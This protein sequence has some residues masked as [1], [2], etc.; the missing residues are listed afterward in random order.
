MACVNVNSP[1]YKDLVKSLDRKERF[2][3]KGV[4]SSYLTKNNTDKLPDFIELKGLM[5]DLYSTPNAGIDYRDMYSEVKSMIKRL[6]P[7]MSEKDLENRVKFVDKLELM[8]LRN[9]L[10]V[11]STFIN[12]TIFISQNIFNE[13][14]QNAITD[15]RHEVFHTIFNNFLSEQEQANIFE[16]FKRDNPKYKNEVDKEVLE[17]AMADLF[18]NYRVDNKRSIPTIIKD[19][20]NEILAFFGLLNVSYNDLN[21]LF[22]DVEQGKFTRDFIKDSL[23]TRDKTIISKFPE[24]KADLDHFLQSKAFMLNNLN[25]LMFPT[26]DLSE[27]DNSNLFL[28]ES[29]TSALF[30]NNKEAF[31]LGLSKEDALSALQKRLTTLK[32]SNIADANLA[33]IVETFSKPNRFE[34]MFNY[35]Q[36]YSEAQVTSNGELSLKETPHVDDTIN[37]PDQEDSRENVANQEIGSKE[38]INPTTKI[39]EVVKDFLSS[40]TYPSSNGDRVSIDPGAGF[41]SLLN[42]MGSLYGNTSIEDNLDTL[43]ANYNNTVKGNTTK[44]V[45]ERLRMLHESVANFDKMTLNVKGMTETELNDLKAKLDAVGIKHMVN[46]TTMSLIIPD[47]MKVENQG[48]NSVDNKIVFTLNRFKEGGQSFRITN[49]KD[50]KTVANK[51]FIEDIAKKTGIPNFVIGKLFQYN[52]QRNQ[53]AELTKVAGSLRKLS[54]KFVKVSTIRQEVDGQRVTS[55]NYSFINKVNEYRQSGSLASI[56]R[57]RLD[58]PA[59]RTSTVAAIKAAVAAK[60]ASATEQ[61]ISNSVKDILV[62]KMYA[63]TLDEFNKIGKKDLTYVLNSLERIV[64]FAPELSTDTPIDEFA[65]YDK[66]LTNT[67]N[68]ANLLTRYAVEKNAPTSF[69]VSTAKK[70][71]WENVMPNTSWKIFKNLSD[72]ATNTIK[73]K[74]LLPFLRNSFN[75]Y[76]KFNPIFQHDYNTQT[77]TV[78][79]KLLK[80]QEDDFYSDHQETYFDNRSSKYIT[81][82]VPFSKETPRDWINRNFL[83]MFMLPIVE[84][85]SAS[86]ENPSYFQQKFQPESAPNVSIIKMG[87][88]SA[89]EMENSIKMMILQQAYMNVQF[90]NSPRGNLAKNSKKSNLP[91]L[92]G[93]TFFIENGENVFFDTNGQLRAKFGS[94]QNGKITL[95]TDEKVWSKFMNPI[96]KNLDSSIDSLV[97]LSLENKATLDGSMMNQM[98]ASLNKS[99]LPQYEMTTEDKQF[100]SSI[101]VN[102]STDISA[103]R[104]EPNFAQQKVALKKAMSVYYLNSFINGFFMNQLSSG[105]TQNY[106]NPLDEIKRQAG[107]NAMNDTGLIDNKHGMRTNYNNVVISS[108]YNFYGQSHPFSKIPLLNRFFLNKKNEVADAQSWDLPEY[109]QML[110]K[111]YGKSVDMGVIT[112]DV[113]FEIN[114]NGGVD[115]RKTSSAELTNELVRKNKTLRDLRFQMT[116]EP[117]LNS[118]ATEDK[119]VQEPRARYLYNKLVDENELNDIDEYMEY[120][121]LLEQVNEGNFMIHKASFESAIKGSKPSKMSGFV[122]NKETG[123]FDFNLQPDSVLNLNSGFNGIQQ[124]V[125]HRAIDSFISHFTQLTYL[126]GLNRT[127]T[128]IK[129]S[130][131]LTRTLGKFTKAGIYD[132]MFDYRMS[133]DEDK[134]LKAGTDTRKAFVA[135]LKKKLDL[136]GNE[137]LMDLL[138]TPGISMNNPL[139]SEKLMQTFFNSFTKKTVNPKHPGGMFVLQSEFGFES[140]RI[141]AENSM[142]TPELKL[143]DKG[144]ILYAEAYLPAMYGGDVSSGAIQTGEML[145]YDNDQYNNMFGFRIPSS[146]LHSSV[147]LKVIGFYPSTAQDNVVVIPSAVTALHGSDFDVDKLFVVRPGVY[148]VSEEGAHDTAQQHQTIDSQDTDSK[149]EFKTKFQANNRIIAQRGIKFGYTVADVEYDAQGNLINFGS[150]DHKEVFA[151]DSI[152]LSEKKATQDRIIELDKVQASQE[153]TIKNPGSFAAKQQARRELKSTKDEIKSLKDHLKTL[154]NIQKGFYSN[155]ILESVL[156]NISYSGENANDILFGIT[157]DPVKGYEEESEYSQLARVYSDINKA[158]GGELL[159]E[160]PV[161]FT[162]AAEA[163]EA[164]PSKYQKIRTQLE[165]QLGVDTTTAEGEAD[166]LALINE[167]IKDDWV[168]VRDEYIRSQRDN[169]GPM[170]INKVEKHVNVHKETYMASDLVGLIANFSKGLAYAFHGIT[171]DENHIE[172]DMPL[173]EDIVIDGVKMDKLTIENKD[174]IKNQ[175]LK[176]LALN[177]AIDHVKEQILNVLN[178]GEK[179]V[180]MFLAAISTEMTMHQ[181]T[182]MMLQPVAKELSGSNA[183]TFQK[184]LNRAMSDIIEAIGEGN[185][186]PDDINNLQITTAALE[187]MITSTLADVISRGKR[188]ELLLQAKVIKQLIT[189]NTIGQ[190][191][192][193]VSAALS[194]IQG[195][196]YNLDMAY[197]KLEAV[198]KLIDVEKFFNKLTYTESS[199]YTAPGFK[200]DLRSS[201]NILANVNLANNENVLAAVEAI[202]VQLDATSELFT[203]NSL[204]MQFLANTY[205]EAISNNA[206]PSTMFNNSKEFGLNTRKEMTTAQK[207]LKGKKTH[208]MTQLISKNILN[209]LTTGLNIP[210]NDGQ[211]TLSLSVQ[212]QKLEYIENIQNYLGPVQSYLNQFLMGEKNLYVNGKYNGNNYL[213]SQINPSWRIKPISLLKLENKDNKF[214]RGLGVDFNFA[215]KV[216]TLTFNSDLVNSAENLA[217][218]EKS[219]NEIG[220]M[221]NIYVM[222][223]E[224]GNWINLPSNSHP[225]TPD[226]NEVIFNIIKSSLYTDKLKFSSGKATNVLP[227]QYFTKIFQSLD[228]VTRDLMLYRKSA[229]GNK[230]Y[231]DYKNN[232]N[233]TNQTSGI[234]DIKENLF[235]NTIFSNPDILPNI[236]GK[237][238]FSNKNAGMLPDGNVYDL[239]INAAKL[240]DTPQEEEQTVDI[241]SPE[242]TQDNVSE[243]VESE[244]TETEAEV[245]L[246]D[247]F[248]KNPSFI[249]EESREKKG[250]FELYMK[251]GQTGTKEENNL[252]YYY[253]KIGVV[254]SRLTNNSFTPDV[255]LNKYQIN[256]YFDPKKLAI[257]VK[258]K[259]ITQSTL[260]LEGVTISSFLV[261]AK[262]N[263]RN[264]NEFKQERAEAQ[265]MYLEEMRR[266]TANA[267]K[268]DAQ[269]LATFQTKFNVENVVK[270]VK[271]VLVYDSRNIDR[272]GARVFDIVGVSISADK[273]KANFDLKE[274]EIQINERKFDSPFVP[275]QNLRE[276]KIDRQQM[277]D[278]VNLAG[279]EVITGTDNISDAELRLRYEKAAEDQMDREANEFINQNNCG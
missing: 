96:M 199:E 103:L 79:Q 113:H 217:D 89:A 83:A 22:Q 57:Q 62:T 178:V 116:F 193:D 118:L 75:N 114:E 270:Q 265:R 225:S 194:I 174:K 109:K 29:Y 255:L 5:S 276:T 121:D 157:F 68:L 33:K 34:A 127:P 51:T 266:D 124:A 223:D 94:V 203:E 184:T 245:G 63:L 61:Q 44:A 251:V 195:L 43:K 59:I 8:R 264:K 246:Y 72:F 39:S 88:Q 239:F 42:L 131:I 73:S 64:S 132:L 242:K 189:L 143:D 28:K 122:R 211:H 235:I 254:N 240:E 177:A 11:L 86:R 74:N 236:Q 153:Q 148:G 155:Q 268:T 208:T 190:Q 85:L 27:R 180:K 14:G 219:I 165:D 226:M 273:S 158:N 50:G 238:E 136:P 154:K 112:K 53:L 104:N 187:P 35:L 206:D 30:Q 69:S 263:D 234:N 181:A 253:K 56:I 139:F 76:L 24:W 248:K 167:D 214:L 130:R 106:K 252:K 37:L 101:F 25:E 256:Q 67:G 138:N 227:T 171:N 1:Q 228:T 224:S 233:Y 274:A 71:K 213:Q 278:T 47:T 215:E 99:F 277:I 162:T 18:E 161:L 207:Y 84:D 173:A 147:P 269:I 129:N 169:S 185:V 244:V 98:V 150:N 146:D 13:R 2:V 4:L 100:L 191:I 267:T 192:S 105:A 216:Q 137:R 151:L 58:I 241:I 46:K 243:E 3:A 209:L 21:K 257:P 168:S 55:T 12:N 32:N 36:P 49:T 40:I 142:R 17:E 160:R 20:F 222:E 70:S 31:A 262:D 200:D 237:Y 41:I 144:N 156:D 182:M 117:W 45:F 125:R 175:E 78:N 271:Q 201:Q 111:S 80:T 149:R 152:L 7:S 220:N 87:V 159:A 135:D 38:L 19:F 108:A 249:T 166:L 9:G 115:Y 52:E 183:D 229:E 77:F 97:E 60:N 92:E 250:R 123:T 179:T 259:D 90:S 16:T 23:V 82:P 197:D 107:V 93:S 164:N 218:M 231:K 141:L 258:N 128:S 210:Y 212:D 54:P 119:A 81:K 65:K 272:I 133:Y 186:T 145:Y 188:E 26:S 275:L 48:T 134:L 10:P 170:N 205:L 204:Q 6:I 202:K 91:G 95:S 102:K 279:G 198:N 232:K 140:N 196:P 163:R 15:I 176:S 247:R 120:Q 172:L 261:N 260:K 230:Y 126:T 110:R 66:F 221:S